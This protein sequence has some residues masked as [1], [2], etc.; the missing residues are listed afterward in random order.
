M[1][2]VHDHVHTVALAAALHAADQPPGDLRHVHLLKLTQTVGA[3]AAVIPAVLP[4]I[5]Q[6]VVPQAFVCEAVKGH[7]LQTLPVPL[8]DDL[9]GHRVQLLV[10]LVVLDKRLV[11]HHVLAAVEQNTLRGLPVPPGAARLLV[12]TLH[13]LWHVVMHHEPHV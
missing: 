3:V 5:P 11:G 9:L 13:V 12:I 1:H 2:R 10:V 4:E 7:F 6:N 8:H